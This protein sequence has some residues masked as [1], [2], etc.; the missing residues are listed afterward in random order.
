MV[1]RFLLFTVAIGVV[2]NP[3]MGFA[4][5]NN[6]TLKGMVDKGAAFLREQLKSHQGA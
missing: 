1:A 6:A 3:P 5:V 4:Q 2:A